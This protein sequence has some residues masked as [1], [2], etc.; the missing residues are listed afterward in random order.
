MTGK[1]EI[2][3]VS[4]IV[5]V[6]NVADYIEPGLDSL[7]DQ[8][9]A[10]PYEI[11]LVDDA[12][13]DGSLEA[14]RRYAETYPGRISLIECQENSGV[15]IARNLGL[16]RACG[17]Y[18][19]FFDPDDLL[20]PETLSR[21]YAA[22]ERHRADIVKGNL[23]LF[24]EQVRK[25]ASDE[26]RQTTFVKDEAVLTTLYEH[27]QIRGHIAG[28]LLRRDRFGQIRFPVGVRMAQDLLYFSDVFAQAR[29]L[30][31]LSE[32]VY[33]YRKHEAGSTGRKYQKGSYV[34]WL[35]AV[36]KTGEFAV[37]DGQ[38]RAHR[39][40]LL[41]SITQIAREVRKI[42]PD[43]AGPALHEIEKRLRRW[44]I[45]LTQLMLQDRLGLRALSRYVK[46]QHAL[47]RIRQNLS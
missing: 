30:V 5:P 10:H 37:S 2:P 13:T 8:D 28:K 19:A 43:L 22:A 47:A 26:V 45:N 15:S 18:L 1:S 42:P 29:T 4:I 39:G 40:L 27:R 36:E 16:D 12:S 44:Q 31:L 32:A 9:F 46:L 41:R 35:D 33:Y 34:D 17:Q 24:D 20:P 25:P 3:V 21:L 38:R 14:C 6:F 7:I 11:I 23:I